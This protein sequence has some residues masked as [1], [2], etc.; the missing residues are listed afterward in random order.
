MDADN[1]DGKGFNQVFSTRAR[2]TKV[3]ITEFK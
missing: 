1:Y 2:V 3:G